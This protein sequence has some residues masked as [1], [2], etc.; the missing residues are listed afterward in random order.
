VVS[1][2]VAAPLDLPVTPPGWGGT[3][4]VDGVASAVVQ[5]R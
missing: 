4:T 5:V 2:R 3:T 1:V